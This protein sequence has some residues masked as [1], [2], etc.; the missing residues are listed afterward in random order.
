MVKNSSRA[1]TS[2]FHATGDE[3]DS[4]GGFNDD[5]GGGGPGVSD[6]KIGENSGGIKVAHT[7]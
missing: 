1:L 7:Q 2:D 6:D 4:G 5:A 3:G